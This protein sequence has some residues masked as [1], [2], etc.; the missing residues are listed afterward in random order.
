[1]MTFLHNLLQRHQTELQNPSLGNSASYIVQPRPQLRFESDQRVFGHP[2]D[3]TPSDELFRVTPTETEFDP[4]LTQDAVNHQ[5]PLTTHKTSSRLSRPEAQVAALD[6]NEEFGRRRVEGD[7]E[8]LDSG[9]DIFY[10][11]PRN[12]LLEQQGIQQKRASRRATAAVTGAQTVIPQQVLTPPQAFAPSRTFS[13]EQPVHQ[14][15]THQAEV[16]D[17][18]GRRIAAVLHGITHRLNDQPVNTGEQHVP[19]NSVGNRVPPSVG[20]Q[21]SADLKGRVP[22]VKPVSGTSAAIHQSEQSGSLQVPNWLADIQTD[23]ASRWREIDRQRESEHVVN[24]TIGRVE[25]RAV[26]DKPAKPV[27]TRNTPSGVMTLDAYLKL[28][29]RRGQV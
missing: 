4:S 15:I 29:N 6:S 5:S 22:A 18:L 26:Q 24:V 20:H 1:M 8:R 13:Q 25:V 3:G 2:V 21:M 17:A 11:T 14:G 19:D 16:D 9:P 12:T 23:F 10:Q 27:A 7:R 28:R